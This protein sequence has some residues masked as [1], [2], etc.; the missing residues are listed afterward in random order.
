MKDNIKG[1]IYIGVLIF[2]VIF[3]FNIID[4]KSKIVSNSS[5]NNYLIN[6]FDYANLINNKKVLKINFDLKHIIEY[7][8]NKITFNKSFEN[9]RTITVVKENDNSI[10]SNPLVYI[11]NTHNKEKYYYSKTEPYNIVP[12][13]VTTSYMLKESLKKYN[14]N[15]IVEERSIIDILNKN[16]WNYASSY[17]VSRG[18]L[19]DVRKKHPSIKYFIDI[20]R[21]SVKKDISTI[22]IN[23]KTYAR[24]L[25]ILGLENKNYKDNQVMIEYINNELNKEYP[26]LSRGIYKKQGKGVNGIYNQDF[27]KNCILI[28]FGGEENTILEVY[29][30]VE[31]VSKIISKYI[32]DNNE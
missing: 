32:G 13:V 18:F 11:Y 16:K 30:T 1:I 3:I 4:N 26:K 7:N 27:S 29:N 5:I 19:N 22:T 2:I 28:E 31:V 8:S 25:F 6:N 10:I 12:T 23:N 9:N 21:D 20:H 14:I 17:R 24:V 15:S